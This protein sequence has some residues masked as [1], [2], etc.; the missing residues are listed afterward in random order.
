MESFVILGVPK[1][2]K[3][4]EYRVSMT[5]AGVHDLV[6]EGHTVFVEDGAGEGSG[7]PNQLYLEHGAQITDRNDIFSRSEIKGFNSYL[8]GCSFFD[9]LYCSNK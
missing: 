9:C 1:E 3:D 7:L 6:V 2:I 8:V 4:D 5:P